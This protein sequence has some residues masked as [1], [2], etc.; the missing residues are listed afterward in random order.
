MLSNPAV[1]RQHMNDTWFRF[2]AV[3]GAFTRY[4]NE[5]IWRRWISR[6][7]HRLRR[8]D[9]LRL[10]SDVPQGLTDRTHTRPARESRS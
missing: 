1:T 10:D 7:M 8:S 4:A 5:A 3:H 6:R 2:G 9:W